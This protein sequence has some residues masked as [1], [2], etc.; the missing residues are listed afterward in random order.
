MNPLRPR[1]LERQPDVCIAVT[2]DDL[3]AT[4]THILG[5][6]GD[7]LWTSASEAGFVTTGMGGTV[8]VPFESIGGACT[9]RCSPDVNVRRLFIDLVRPMFHLALLRKGAVAIH[10]SAVVYEGKGVLFAGWSESGKTEAMIGF[11]NA[12]AQFV[13]DKWTI[14]SGDGSSACHFPTPITIR[15]WMLEY[16]PRLGHSISARDRWRSR[17]GSRLDALLPSPIGSG[18]AGMIGRAASFLRPAAGLASRVSVTPAQLTSSTG[19]ASPTVPLDRIFL[20][21]TSSTPGIS[22][23]PVSPDQVA[24]RLADCAQYERRAF[25]GLYDRF[26]YS[27]PGRA[28]TLIE[29]ARE[30][31]KEML[32]RALH[33]RAMFQVESPFPF[34]PVAFYEAI[35]PYC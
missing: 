27:F 13:S 8:T 15:G 3:T 14:V 34:D 23:Q 2:R 12:G 11:L 9:L 31:E 10:S 4:K 20:L 1:R 24:S 25:F 18:A 5:D 33:D 7:G 17:V 30:R 35:A 26:R 16:L 19:S 29:E 6:A 28:N 21:V 22:V 32:A